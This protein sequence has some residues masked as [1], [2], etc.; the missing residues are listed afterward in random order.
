MT[1]I[2][3]KKTVLATMHY[4]FDETIWHASLESSLEGV[5]V[6]QAAWRPAEGKNN[7]WELVRHITLWKRGLLD[8]WEAESAHEAFQDLSSE[9]WLP[10]PKDAVWE[11]DRKKLLNVSRAFIE[12]IAAESD[13][14]LCK[15][16]EGSQTAR[17]WNVINNATHDA[18]HAGQIMYLRKLQEA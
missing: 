13:E 12:K 2:D 8:N 7:I 18:Y 5:T 9:D 1:G 10:V 6:E 16:P 4:G 11:D 3:V 14:R 17:V 15:A